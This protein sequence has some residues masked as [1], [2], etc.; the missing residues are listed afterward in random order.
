MI[1]IDDI[2][3]AA[4]EIGEVAKEGNISIP[5]FMGEGIGENVPF[6]EIAEVDGDLHADNGFM[7]C[8]L[9]TSPSPRDLAPTRM[10]SSA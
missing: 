1:G 4:T 6:H 2:C 9:Y 3:M 5:N 8:L 7:G 10:P